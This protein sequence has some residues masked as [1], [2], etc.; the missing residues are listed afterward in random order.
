MTIQNLSS[1]F[2]QRQTGEQVDV[3]ALNVQSADF[4]VRS[5]EWNVELGG[6]VDD[7]TST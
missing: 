2:E 5:A 7:R 4:G 3:V 1:E 6:I